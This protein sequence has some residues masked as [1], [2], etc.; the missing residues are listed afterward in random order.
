[1]ASAFSYFNKSEY[2]ERGGGVKGIK[3]GWSFCVIVILNFSRHLA[4]S[5]TS[6]A[7]ADES[8][9]ST[10]RQEQAASK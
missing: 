10:H 7:A 1:M 2:A 6:V 4:L 3:K 5:W 8:G 9:R